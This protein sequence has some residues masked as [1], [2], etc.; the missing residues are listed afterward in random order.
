MSAEFKIALVGEAWGQEE[1]YVR[2][3]FIGAAGQELNRMLKDAGIARNDCYVTN[4]FNL[5]P[6]KNNIE[7]FLGPKAEASSLIPGPLVPAK[8][9]K[10]EFEPELLRLYS[11]LEELRPNL[12]VLLGN[13]A[14]WALLHDTKISKLRGAVTY[15]KA[16]P[17]LKCLPTYHPAA[18]L[19]QWDL[20]HVTVIDLQKAKLESEFSEVIRPPREIWL[21]PTIEEIKVFYERF[22]LKTD[23]MAFDIET[24]YGVQITC[25]GFAPSKDR[26]ICIPIYD[27]RK[28]NGSYWNPLEEELE[29]WDWIVKYLHSP[30]KKVA[31]NGLFDMQHL[32][33]NYGITV[34]NGGEDCMLMHHSLHPEAPKALDFLGSVYSNEVAWKTHRPKGKK[35]SLKRDD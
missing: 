6:P 26:A 5:Q 3:P 29:A 1:A 16:L 35:D 12:A 21:D 28:A 19:R 27:Y 20:R 8:Y 31:Q 33:Q 17:W 11:E 2:K 13:T 24:N 9:L 32:W 23:Y 14:C 7:F 18:V 34:T 10:K 25:I 15:S 30:C 4:C 22:V